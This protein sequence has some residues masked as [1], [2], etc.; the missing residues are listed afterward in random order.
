MSQAKR[1]RQS[2]SREGEQSR[3]ER[4]FQVSDAAADGEEVDVDEAACVELVVVVERG[5][6]G[7]VGEAVEE[8]RDRADE[9]LLVEG[10]RRGEGGIAGREE[11][12]AK[13]ARLEACLGKR[14][15]RRKGKR[16]RGRG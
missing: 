10:E 14:G 12:L 11:G 1:G 6:E 9:E 3:S 15:R 7:E 8:R 4:E 16:R 5:E 13:E 2:K